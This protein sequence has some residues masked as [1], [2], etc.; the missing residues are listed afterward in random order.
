ML[1]RSAGFRFG[2]LYAGLFGASAAA[3]AVFLWWSTAGLLQ[4][5]TDD[6]IWRDMND[7]IDQYEAGNISALQHTIDQRVEQDVADTAIYLLVDR[8]SQILAGN[9]RYWPQEVPLQP[10]FYSLR[11]SRAGDVT[12]A[13]ARGEEL[14]GDFHLLVGRDTRTV[15]QITDLLAGALLW[16]AG[17]VVVLAVMGAL[18]VRSLFRMQLG[19][20]SVTAAA[21][22]AGDLSRRVRR[23]GRADEFDMLAETINDML[24]RI[25]RLMDGVRQVSNAI[26]H[27]LRTPITRARARLEDA[28]RTG[29]TEAELRGAIERAVA[30]LDGVVRVFA[31]LLRIAEIESGARRGAFRP[32][33]LAP[34][35]Q[36]VADLYEAVAEEKRCRLE[37][38]IADRLPAFGDLEMIQQAVANLLDNAVKFSPP[39]GTVVLSG[40]MQ[41]AAPLIEICDQGPGIPPEDLG[42]ATERFY[43][44]EGARST[45]GSGL[46]LA[47]VQAVATL[48]GG[49]LRLT[50]SA[51][52]LC[53]ALTLLPGPQTSLRPAAPA[54]GT[55]VD[56][57]SSA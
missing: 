52:G 12:P 3:L 28:A 57:T 46:G 53:A 34:V 44:G 14:P 13:E 30:D 33:D 48:H 19:E 42:H 50:G 43:R 18:F 20:V 35:L 47:L 23:T 9:L 41:A 51:P 8:Y 25:G 16:C 22:G 29:A 55:N 56:Q 4:R 17:I 36:D 10:G 26:A 2:L 49:A 39:G 40:T 6:V 24:D 45:P 15:R 7:L 27:D 31:A 21:I 32:L 11:I 1:V 5:Q 37:R 38:R 54:A